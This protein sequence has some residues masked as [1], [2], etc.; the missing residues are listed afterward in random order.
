MHSIKIFAFAAFSLIA[1]D[2]AISSASAATVCGTSGR[3]AIAETRE[4]AVGAA[5]R[6]ARRVAWHYC[7]RDYGSRLPYGSTSLRD[8]PRAKII[9]SRCHAVQVFNHPGVKCWTKVTC[10][11][12][13]TG[14]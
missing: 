3:S 14:G 13:I 2:A 7:K 10:I 11:A 8:C 1:A 5:S 12:N 4:R 9:R 6:R